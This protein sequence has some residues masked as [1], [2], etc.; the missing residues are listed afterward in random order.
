[1]AKICVSQNQA[2][3]ERLS[4]MHERKFDFLRFIWFVA[5]ET[6]K[7]DVKIINKERWW[8]ILKNNIYLCK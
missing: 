1:M 2:L 6:I 7:K 8:R 3:E 4:N 5:C